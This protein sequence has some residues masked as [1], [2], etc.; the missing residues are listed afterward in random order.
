MGAFLGAVSLEPSNPAYRFYR[1]C[2]EH[3]YQRQGFRSVLSG[4]IASAIEGWFGRD[5]VPPLIRDRV[6]AGEMFLWPLMAVLWAFD[7]E[8]VA[9]RSLIVKWIAECPSA[10]ECVNAFLEA[11]DK[12][13]AGLRDV[14]NLPRHEDM[15]A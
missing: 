11:R 2:L 10:R 15:R 9:R 7:V 4:A 1:D 6:Q 14:E 8:S 5:V 3:I 13:G 12:L